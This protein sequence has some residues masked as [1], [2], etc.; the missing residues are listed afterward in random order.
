MTLSGTDMKQL[1]DQ[2]RDYVFCQDCEQRLNK[3]GE[4][5]VLANIPGDYDSA[6]PLR[7]ALQSLTPTFVGKDLDLYDVTGVSAFEMDKL[8]YF[9]ISV[10]WRGT[11]TTGRPLVGLRLLGLSFATMRSQSAS[12]SWESSLSRAV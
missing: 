9:G 6:F 12:S 8:L 11:A 7:T 1:S 2:L 4:R 5:W 10:F 3:N